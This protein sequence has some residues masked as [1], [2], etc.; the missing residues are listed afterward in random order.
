[1]QAVSTTPTTTTTTTTT[2]TIATT[3]TTVAPFVAPQG[4]DLIAQGTTAHNP[5]GPFQEFRWID[6]LATGTVSLT[7]CAT[8]CTFTPGCGRIIWVAPTFCLMLSGH[9]TLDLEVTSNKSYSLVRQVRVWV[10]FVLNMNTSVLNRYNRS[11]GIGD[12]LVEKEDAHEVPLTW[13]V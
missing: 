5:S 1:M 11:S 10:T 12:F 6:A 13:N 4:Y 8:L 9:N 2:T 7:G 3:T